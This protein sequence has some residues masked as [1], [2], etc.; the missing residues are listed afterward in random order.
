MCSGECGDNYNQS[1][2]GIYSIWPIIGQV[3][4][5]SL[6]S[7]MW[8]LGEHTNKELLIVMDIFL[9]KNYQENV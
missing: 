2:T 1:K 9:K 3:S 4:D 5:K 7:K 8:T 6:S